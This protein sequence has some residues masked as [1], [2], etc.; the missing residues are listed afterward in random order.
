MNYNRCRYK[1]DMNT[2]I[3]SYKS[4]NALGKLITGLADRF[5]TQ[6]QLTVVSISK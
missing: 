2:I 5:T 4:L 3:Y 1:L 6:N